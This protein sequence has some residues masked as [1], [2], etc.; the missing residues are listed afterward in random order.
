MSEEPLP[1]NL[2]KFVNETFI[3]GLTHRESYSVEEANGV[4]YQVDANLT[5]NEHGVVSLKEDTALVEAVECSNETVRISFKTEISN[6]EMVKLMFPQ[7]S[8]FAIDSDKYGACRLEEEQEGG[9]GFLVIFEVTLSSDKK[10]V[11]ISGFPTSYFFVFDE[12]HVLMDPIDGSGRSLFAG[13]HTPDLR[14]RSTPTA[15]K[16]WTY[17]T[18]SSKFQAESWAEVSLTGVVHPGLVWHWYKFWEITLELRFGVGLSASVGHRFTLERGSYSDSGDDE[19]GKYPILGFALPK[20]PAFDMKME[21]G[22]FVGLD[23]FWDYNVNSNLG[24][25]MAARASV[26]TGYKEWKLF[27]KG[28][29]IGKPEWGAPLEKYVCS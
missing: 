2:Q 1:A 24:V 11:E 17:N 7:A 20:P 22:A 13:N 4:Q 18:G 19:L 14:S 15:T 28:S 12:A 16:S 6:V 8:V 9:H 21:V 27:I 23:Y 5:F 26:S 10:Q 29:L 25:R 3:E